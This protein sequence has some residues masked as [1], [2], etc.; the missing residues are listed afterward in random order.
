MEAKQLSYSFKLA[1]AIIKLDRE[2]D[3]IWEELLK[4]EG[5]RALEILRYVQNH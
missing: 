2:R 5:E 4:E 1:S 3:E